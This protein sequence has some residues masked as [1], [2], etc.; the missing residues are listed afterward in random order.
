[1][2]VSEKNSSSTPLNASATFTGQVEDVLGFSA[3]Y[4]SFKADKTAGITFLF[5]PDGSNFDQEESITIVNGYPYFQ[6]REIKGRY[7]KVRVENLDT[8][9]NMSYMRLQSLLKKEPTNVDIDTMPL[10]TFEISHETSSV[11]CF[12]NGTWAVSATDLDVR[13]LAYATDSVTAHQGGSWT[14]SATD[15]DVRDLAYASDS[16]TAHQGGSWTVSATDLD[17]RDLAYASDSIT[18]HQGGSW[19]VSATDLD[20][21]DLVHASDSVEAH[22]GGTWNV[23]TS[24]LA[25]SAY[26]N[27]DLGLTSSQVSASTCSIISLHA[28][29]QSGL[30]K[31]YLKVYQLT[32]ADETDTPILTYVLLPEQSI[33]V[34]MVHPLS[35][36]SC[37]LRATTG[38]HDGNTGAPDSHD[39]VVNITYA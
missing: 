37:C 10:Q 13:D 8:E 26:R 33:S 38:I 29:N 11:E 34:Q 30:Q 19:S 35:L 23:S 4:V 24:N 1:M 16:I 7:M 15:L 9:Y 5:S 3:L 28:Q 2:S 22:Q 20:I 27:I 18:A 21:R 31:R 17:V 39:V 25:T 14:V 32:T 6:S 36:T 12:Q